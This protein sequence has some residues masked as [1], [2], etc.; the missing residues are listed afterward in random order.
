MLTNPLKHF[1]GNM[2]FICLLS[3]LLFSLNS[4]AKDISV[5]V[6]GTVYACS[7]QPTAA[8]ECSE[9]AKGFAL[10]L[11]YCDMTYTG[12]YCADKYWPVYKQTHPNCLYQGMPSCLE[13]CD[14]TYTGGYC[15]EKCQ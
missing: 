11:Q 7:G 10:Q 6:D 13:Y 5:T 9:A 1:G 2:K 12:G 8:S 14:M 4:M 15:A 3:I